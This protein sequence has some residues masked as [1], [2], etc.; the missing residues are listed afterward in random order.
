MMN[1]LSAAF[2]KAFCGQKSSGKHLPEFIFNAPD[3]FKQLM[4]DNLVKGDGSRSFGKAYSQEYRLKNFK[5]ESESLRLISGLST[6]LLQIGVSHSVGYWPSK[7]TY[8]IA[9]STKNNN[10]KRSPRV[11][12]QSYEGYVYD[13]SV[14]GYHT[15][16]DS[17][18]SIVLKNTD[19]LFI[20]NPAKDKVAEVLKWADK[21]L[22]VELEVD[23]VYRYVA[24]SERKK[25]YFGVL[26]DGKPDIKGLTGKKSQT[27]EFLKKEF[28]EMLDILGDVYSQDDFRQAKSNIKKLLTDMVASLKDRRVP[29]DDLSFNVMMGKSID[30][31]RST[32]GPEPS[33]REPLK[34]ESLA[35][36]SQ[37]AEKGQEFDNSSMSGLPQHVKAA[38]LLRN[39][40]KEVKA[41]EIISFVKTKGGYGVKP[42]VQAK[43]EDI[44]VEKYIEYA[45]SM[46]DQVLSALDLSFESVVPRSSLDAFWS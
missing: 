12:E 32:K 3:E 4:L 28:Y 43:P 20:E 15:F 13:L 44:D 17:C 29:I 5:Y 38:M 10:T 22:G 2:F 37:E 46:F 42:T 8:S 11:L 39:S 9:T 33:K 7:R 36:E 25:N 14:D 26:E 18:G 27:P 45:S 16:A 35:Q 23:K 24:F 19:S 21:E 41:G 6:I 40:N 1:K 34:Q 31:Y 30:G